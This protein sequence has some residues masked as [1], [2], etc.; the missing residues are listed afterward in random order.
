MINKINQNSVGVLEWFGKYEKIL[1]PGLRFN[2]PFIEKVAT[3]VSFRQQNFK[4]SGTYPSK[5]KV[6]VTITTN[7][8]FIVKNTEDDIKKF[9][10]T[11]QDANASV[12]AMIENS[13]RSYIAKETHEGIL[14]KKDELSTHIKIYIESK[15]S[16]WG[17]SNSSF[18]I[19]D[20][21]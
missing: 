17:I 15:F 6:M 1:Q 4:L 12:G 20:I 21:I 3:I 19:I 16:E 10:Y 7:L 9:V 2:I 13:L 5:D 11:L 14:E 8:I 18:H